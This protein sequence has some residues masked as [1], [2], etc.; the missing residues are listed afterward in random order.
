MD[1]TTRAKRKAFREKYTSMTFCMCLLC[2]R[3]IY[4]FNVNDALLHLTIDHIKPDSE[5]GTYDE[6]NTQPAHYKCNNARGSNSLKISRRTDLEKG[7]ETVSCSH[8]DISR[9][10]HKVV[11][12][13]NL[14]TGIINSKICTVTQSGVITNEE[15]MYDMYGNQLNAQ[16]N[17][18]CYKRNHKR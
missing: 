11:V 1:K 14:N 7:I 4:N 15:I 18:R 13:Y 2:G 3:L 6:H 10:R 12:T 16:H 5:G 9:T 8:T 17:V